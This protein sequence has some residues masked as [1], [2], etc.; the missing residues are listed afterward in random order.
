MRSFGIFEEIERL[1]EYIPI[2][3]ENHNSGLSS[4]N[5]SSN[6]DNAKF[7]RD[8]SIDSKFYFNDID[9]VA[10]RLGII[11]VIR[12]RRKRN[13]NTNDDNDN[14]NYH[15]VTIVSFRDIIKL[16]NK[17]LKDANIEELVTKQRYRHLT[18]QIQG[19]DLSLKGILFDFCL[20]AM[21]GDTLNAK[22][23]LRHAFYLLGLHTRLYL[24][25]CVIVNESLVED[26]D[27][28]EF[29]T[30][31]AVATEPNNIDIHFNLNHGGFSKRY[32]M[33]LKQLQKLTPI[34]KQISKTTKNVSLVLHDE[35]SHQ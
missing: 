28:R 4:N 29:L 26:K 27:I 16:L 30:L 35:E 31:L 21:E 5:N 14:S 22:L 10:T 25:L 7:A 9:G 23:Y 2:E 33:Y 13:N 24:L 18:Q 3:S 15:Y 32:D 34:C 20:A 6:I 11:E 17:F 19:F 1:I 12:R 8:T